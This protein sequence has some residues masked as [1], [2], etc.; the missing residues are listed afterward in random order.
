[1]K[2][3][4]RDEK[5]HLE[6]EHTVREAI[7]EMGLSP[8]DLV[9]VRDDEVLSRDAILHHEDKVKLLPADSRDPPLL[10]DS[11]RLGRRRNSW[12][13]MSPAVGLAARADLPA[14]RQRRR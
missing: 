9:V 4:Y 12:A 6:G 10:R 8:D 1:M 14:V 13:V 11:R 5:W 3:Y 7:E 2:G